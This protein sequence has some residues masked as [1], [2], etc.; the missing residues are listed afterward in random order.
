[1]QGNSDSERTDSPWSSTALGG[2]AHESELPA[3]VSQEEGDSQHGNPGVQ[4]E[5]GC[6]L[7]EEPRTSSVSYR[8]VD[9]ALIVLC[10]GAEF[11]IE[12]VGWTMEEVHAIVECVRR[13]DWSLFHEVM[14][15]GGATGFSG[16][17]PI[18]EGNE[19]IPPGVVAIGSAE[20]PPR[21]R[22]PSSVGGSGEQI[23]EG[24]EEFVEPPWAFSVWS[25][26]IIQVGQGWWMFLS[27]VFVLWC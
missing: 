16:P 20:P 9:G 18:S 5:K 12:L 24:M 17:R 3:S 1:M 15:W 6:D 10:S 21:S 11:R 22:T 23:P 25:E 14:S 2:G 13:G 19:G 7:E 26:W 8:A 4:E 27:G